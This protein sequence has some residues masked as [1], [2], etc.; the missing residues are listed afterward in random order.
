MRVHGYENVVLRQ[1]SEANTQA[2]D[3]IPASLMAEAQCAS[4]EVG[5]LATDQSSD[6]A[7]TTAAISSIQPNATAY[8]FTSCES[9]C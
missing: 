8:R 7:E 3:Q 6:V 9:A 2:L 5:Q 4:A 1:E